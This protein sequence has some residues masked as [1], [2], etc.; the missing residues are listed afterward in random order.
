MQAK[1]LQ[2][3]ASLNQWGVSFLWSPFTP[4]IEQ[5][6]KPERL[7]QS[8]IES[9]SARLRLGVIAFLL[10]H[11]EEAP[12]IHQAL[13]LVKENKCLL[14]KYYY[15]AA[16]YLQTLWKS[17]LTQFGSDMLPNYFSKDVGLPDP[18][19]LHGRLGLAALEEALQ[20]LRGEAYNYT[21]SFEAVVRLI[22]QQGNSH[23]TTR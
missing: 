10:V 6:L 22:Q 1:E 15:T 11:P 19:Q 12:A 20:Q 3:I 8:L 13:S 17:Q 9:D 5:P 21:A 23:A 2:A 4:K 18:I 7:I 14:L 16:V